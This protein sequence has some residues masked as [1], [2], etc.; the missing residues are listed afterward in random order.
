MARFRVLERLWIDT[1]QGFFGTFGSA[2]DSSYIGDYALILM[3]FGIDGVLGLSAQLATAVSFDDLP[4]ALGAGL[5]AHLHL[6]RVRF[7]VEAGF[8]IGDGGQQRFGD[9]SAGIT[10]DFG[11]G[12]P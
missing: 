12:T 9:F 7:G 5:G 11:L 4:A 1:R 6:G 3:P 8:G 2:G 10:L